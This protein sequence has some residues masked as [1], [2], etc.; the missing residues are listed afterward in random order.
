MNRRAARWL[1]PILIVIAAALALGVPAGGV[2]AVGGNGRISNLRTA[3]DP[4]PPITANEFLPE[5]RNLSDCV[6][7]L[8][9]P[10]CGSEERGG[11]MMT[12][13]FAL[14]IGGMAFVFW[15]VIVGVRKNRA[16]LDRSESVRSETDKAATERPERDPAEPIE[17]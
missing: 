6:G 15:R 16:E 12:L 13:V 10:G 8:E 3:P 11:P 4:E 2:T 5:D 1:A 14:V 9:K 7:V 17:P